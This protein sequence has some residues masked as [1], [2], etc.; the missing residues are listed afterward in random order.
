MNFHDHILLGFALLLVPRP[1]QGDPLA[2]RAS[3]F[4]SQLAGK[5]LPYWY[6]TALDRTNGGYLLADDLKGRGVA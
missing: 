6:D 3:D 4:K 2:S 5:I 1:A